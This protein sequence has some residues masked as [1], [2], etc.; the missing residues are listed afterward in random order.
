MACC[1]LRL[2]PGLDR[3]L[4]FAPPFAFLL[5]WQDWLRALCLMAIGEKRAVTLGVAFLVGECVIRWPLLT[6]ASLVGSLPTILLYTLPAALHNG[7]P[8]AERGA[9]RAPRPRARSCDRQD[10]PLPFHCREGPARLRGALHDCAGRRSP[11]TMARARESWGT[12]VQAPKRGAAGR[13]AG[14]DGPESGNRP[15]RGEHRSWEG[16]GACWRWNRES[17]G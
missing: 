8:G 14:R 5:A 10:A 15:G 17:F 9:G 11:P 3:S 6:A 12:A 7:R 1:T 13:N 4:P 2:S 16:P